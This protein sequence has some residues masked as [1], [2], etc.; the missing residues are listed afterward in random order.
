VELVKVLEEKVDM[1]LRGDMTY[2]LLHARKRPSYYEEREKVLKACMG[3]YE[4]GLVM[5]TD[6]NVSVRIKGTDLMAIKGSG[7]PYDKLTA[8]DI[9]ICKLDGTRIKGEKK[10]SSEVGLH[11]GIYRARQD[12]N[13]IVHT[14]SVNASILACARKDIPTFHYTVAEIAGDTDVIKCAEYHTYGTPELA[15]AVVKA[16]GKGGKGCLMANHGQATCGKGLEEALYKALRMENLCMQYVR[17][18]SIGGGVVLGKKDMDDCRE[19]NKTYGQ[20]EE[21]EGTGHGI[22]CCK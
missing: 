8:R 19:R 22:G 6:G 7:I 21:G 3:C 14:H 18:L 20:V 9:V 17:L 5:G 13:G 12:V 16:I 11:S 10:P 15:D 2:V 4:G 1:C